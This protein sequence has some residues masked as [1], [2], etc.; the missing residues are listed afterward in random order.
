MRNQKEQDTGKA[1]EVKCVARK[2]K[3]GNETKEAKLERRTK[4]HKNFQTW[5][6]ERKKKQNKRAGKCS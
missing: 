5:Q 1:E 6:G 4:S 3:K 2:Q